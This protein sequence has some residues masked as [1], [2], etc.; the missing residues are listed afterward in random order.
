MDKKFLGLI[1]IILLVS[2]V[3][4]ISNSL[5]SSS[6]NYSACIGQ[7][8][9]VLSSPNYNLLLSLGSPSG[10]SSGSIFKLNLGFI[11]ECIESICCNFNSV[12]EEREIQNFCPDCKTTIEV[13]PF[14]SLYKSL[15]N[16]SINFSDSRY[17]H[18]VGL[19]IKIK[20]SVDEITWTNSECFSDVTIILNSSQ[21]FQTCDWSYGKSF[22]RCGNYVGNMTLTYFPEENK[23]NINGICKSDSI[24][25]GI[26]KITVNISLYKFI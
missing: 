6:A 25:P 20:L 23:I 11:S 14:S 10:S 18:E 4:K 26:H 17:S 1:A 12:C 22:I 2:S 21:N 8:G 15:V 7:Q 3:P 9:T 16:V 24:P 19:R 5:T 13:I